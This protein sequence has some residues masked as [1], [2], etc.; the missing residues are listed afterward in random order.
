[1]LKREFKVLTNIDLLKSKLH[2]SLKIFENDEEGSEQILKRENLV[3]MSFIPS[4]T[5]S[6]KDETKFVYL[7]AFQ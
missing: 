3:L 2:F 6:T 5:L 7:F 4:L 1:M